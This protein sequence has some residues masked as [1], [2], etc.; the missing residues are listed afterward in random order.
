VLRSGWEIALDQ[1]DEAIAWGA[2]TN[3]VLA[4]AGF[5]DVGDFLDVLSERRL[6]YVV[7]V[8]S[9]L[10]PAEAPAGHGVP[11]TVADVTKSFKRCDHT[12]VTRR[13]CSNCRLT[14]RF[15]AIRVRAA[16][17][18]RRDRPTGGL[19]WHLCAWPKGETAPNR[20]WLLTLRIKTIL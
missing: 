14:T 1:V 4:E 7:I 15:T 3:L 9:T 19:Q 8:A 11:V 6:Q 5:G 12:T 2:S 10:P 16:T 20:L 18:R 17:G 13:E